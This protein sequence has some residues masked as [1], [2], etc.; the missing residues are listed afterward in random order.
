MEDIKY[1]INTLTLPVIPMRGM[2]IFPHTVIH[3]DV[4]REKS[5]NALDKALLDN[6]L[7]FLTSQKDIKI[8]D[9]TSKDYY[10]IGTIAEVKQTL[11]MPNGSI[12]VLIE[13]VSRGVIDSFTDEENFIEANIDEY[14]YKAEDIVKSD[15]LEAASRL[16]LDDAKKFIKLSPNLSPDMMMAIIDLDDPSR[17]ADIVASYIN[18][19][20]E[21]YYS[22]ISK[23]GVYDRLVALH[24]MMTKEIAYLEI[25]ESINRKVNKQLNKNQKEYFLREQIQIIKKELGESEDDEAYIEEYIEKIKK[26]KLKKDSEEHVLK[27]ANRLRNLNPGSPE[28]NIIRTYLDH[29]LEIPWNKSTKESLDIKKARKLLDRDHYG[30]EDVKERVLEFIAVRKMTKGA[31]GSILCLVGPPGVGKTSI[32]KSIAEATNRKFVNMRLGGVRDEA[33]IR[34]H[35][36]TYVGA[37]PGRIASLLEKAESNNPV[38]LFDE[39]DKLASDFR[40]D[41]ASALLEVLDPE[42]NDTFM[43]NFL[44]IPM[45]L[46]KVMFVTTAN[47]LDTIPAPLLDRMEVIRIAGYTENEKFEIAQKY[48][49]PKQVKKNGLT[50]KQFHITRDALKTIINNYTR[51]A[52]V[53]NLERNI[54]KVVRKAVIKIVESKR[55]SIEVNKGNLEN[56]LGPKLII[57]DAI[58]RED[59]VGVTNGLAW[60]EVG[61]E[62]LTIEANVLEGSGKVQLTGQLGD[63]M[64][65]SAM[66]AISYIRS[67]QKDFKIN[68][69]FYKDS[70]IHIHVPEGAVPKDG[71]S[72]GVT[73]T[74]AL[75]SALT[76]KKVRHDVA[77]TGEITLRGRVLPIGGLKEKVLAANRYEIKEII[78]PFENEKDL[79]EIPNSIKKQMKFNL[80]KNIDEVLDIAIVK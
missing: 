80:V 74:T 58:S 10:N 77:M 79:E 36:K 53:R 21:D 47:S 8:E 60:T 11:K 19:Q 31:Q 18:I 46:S 73:I 64:K 63:V 71:P 66:A 4:G 78:L 29:I 16:I 70:D 28:V 26:L 12:R 72:A 34:G 24:A 33:E 2:W 43:D 5:I 49:V 62:I 59:I 38:F 75:V 30:L 39:I 54:Q 40:G 35:R 17:L 14:S 42:Q 15:E 41:P 44:E 76:G 45:D 55:K 69:D 6:S 23:F 7:V 51:E 56:Y 48:L 65:E 68:K 67:H 52:G 37:M 25:E 61:G 50:K 20:G 1:D 13:G 22:I 57:D 3:F 32:V 9:P 27:E